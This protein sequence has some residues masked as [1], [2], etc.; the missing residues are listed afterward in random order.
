MRAPL[1]TTWDSAQ[2]AAF[3]GV[4]MTTPLGAS[5]ERRLSLKFVFAAT[6]CASFRPTR[7]T[8]AEIEIA[9]SSSGAPLSV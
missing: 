4:S 5:A 6:V 3:C 9:V 7:L 8:F 1:I 2:T